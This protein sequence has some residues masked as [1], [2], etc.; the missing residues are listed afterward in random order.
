MSVRDQEQV[1]IVLVDIG[2][3][4]ANDLQRLLPD[5]RWQQVILP[6]PSLQLC[7]VEHEVGLTPLVEAVE[8]R[9]LELLDLR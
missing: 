4:L 9:Q 1:D 2:R 7:V 6:A 3:H 8:I 5:H